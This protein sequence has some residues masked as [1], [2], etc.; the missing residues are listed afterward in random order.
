ML[1]WYNADRRMLSKPSKILFLSVILA[2]CLSCVVVGNASERNFFYLPKAADARF[3]EIGKS[4][5]EKG[6]PFTVDRGLL[7]CIF[8]AGKPLVMFLVEDGLEADGV[9]PKVRSVTIS[10]DPFESMFGNMAENDLI[11]DNGDPERRMA[12]FMPLYGVGKRLCDQ[13]KGSKIGSGEL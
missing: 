5:N 10:P 7:G 8:A 13:P 11:D 2:S 1:P 12:L 4:D 9:T 3:Q 6:W